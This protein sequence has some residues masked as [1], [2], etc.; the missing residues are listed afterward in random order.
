MTVP[1]GRPLGARDRLRALRGVHQRWKTD[2]R[3]FR[4]LVGQV[5]Q[6][7]PD[8]FR[9]R[10][11]NVAIVVAEWPDDE[12]AEVGVESGAPAESD[13]L[14]LYQGIPYGERLQG[15]TMTLPDRITI[16][17]QP[18]L[19][20]ARTEAAAREEIRLT[21]LHEIGHYFGLGDDELP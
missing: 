19:A 11:E 16:Y 18:I 7:L 5:V 3:L 10:L 14:G 12:E 21:V 9:S 2:R 17:R 8:E 6:T 13:L 20:S 1:N 15:Y 4:N